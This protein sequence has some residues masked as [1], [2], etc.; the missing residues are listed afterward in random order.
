MRRALY[1]G[2]T[3]GLNEP[4]LYKMSGLV[5]QMMKD[6]YPELLE[7][8]RHVA[9]AI[10][11]EEE[12]YE[13]TTRIGI[14]EL[15][16]LLEG[17]TPGK[18]IPGWEVGP[19]G[20]DEGAEIVAKTPGGKLKAVEYK[21]VPGGTRFRFVLPGK[22]LFKLHDTFG[23]RPDFVED[24]VRTQGGSVDR[25]GYEVKMQ[26]QRERARASWKGVEK[27][28]ASA[29]FLKLAEDGKTLFDGY[30]QT[31]STNCRVVA[32]IVKGESVTEVKPGSEVEIVLDHT[33]FYAEAGGQVGD[34]GFLF[35]PASDHEVAHVTNTYYPVSSL[36]AH[37]A[38]PRD[39]LRVGDLVTAK[40]DVERRDATR[41]NHTAHTCSTRRFAAR[42]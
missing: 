41:R 6:A 18:L 1:H 30:T 22:D 10:K 19:S 25:T 28:T 7:T 17:L 27:K 29:V 39:R 16:K 36:I 14:E 31:T 15:R 20:L 21:L 42:W 35:A 33:P 40:V 4:F 24:I 5:A 12:R 13:K 32:L 23:L 3:L 11:I 9:K 26:Q 37:K 2:Q 34:T 8:E 38:V